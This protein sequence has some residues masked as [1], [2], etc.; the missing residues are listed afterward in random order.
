MIND[1]L[2]SQSY[3]FSLYFGVDDS[4]SMVK[5]I[6]VTEL[7]SGGTA[8][9]LKF[10]APGTQDVIYSHEFSGPEVVNLQEEEWVPYSTRTAT[11]PATGETVTV[12]AGPDYQF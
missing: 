12:M 11:V 9:T 6:T 10:F 1:I 4:D 7:N 2:I 5:R 8:T 3:Y